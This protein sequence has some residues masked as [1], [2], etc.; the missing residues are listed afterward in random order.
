M[1]LKHEEL[2]E[3]FKG[4]RYIHVRAVCALPLLSAHFLSTYWAPTPWVQRVV[5]SLPGPYSPSLADSSATGMRH[6]QGSKHIHYTLDP[7]LK[8]PQI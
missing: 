3:S 8:A 4:H 7:D 5:S 6:L 1:P 2:P